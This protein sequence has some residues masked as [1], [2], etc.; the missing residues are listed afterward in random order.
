[1]TSLEIVKNYYDCFNRKDWQGMLD[2]VDD[3]VV[4]FPNEGKPRYGKELFAHF[5]NK[6]DDAYE[7]RLEEL[8][9]YTTSD[10]GKVS[11][12][13][14]VH[15]KYKVSEEGLPPAHGQVYVLPA[16]AFLTVRNGRIM[17]VTTYYNLNEWIEKVSE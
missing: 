3:A 14:M 13:F 2:L 11:V 15:G 6:M 16:A 5:L 17:S 1:M 4:H 8:V 9:F 10:E 7:E 12:Q